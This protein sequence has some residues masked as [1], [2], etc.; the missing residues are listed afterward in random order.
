MLALS[1][2]LKIDLFLYAEISPLLEQVAKAE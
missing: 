2:V 1:S